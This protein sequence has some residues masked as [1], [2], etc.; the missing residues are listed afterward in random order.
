M[1][2]KK[3]IKCFDFTEKTRN[4]IELGTNVRLVANQNYIKLQENSS[5]YYPTDSDLYVKTW[6]TNPQSVK[7]WLLFESE[8]THQFDD[9]NDQITGD[10]YRLGDGTDEYWWN[11]ASWEV[12]TSDWNTEQE[13]SDNISTF[14]VTS[15]KIQVI[16]NLSTTDSEYTPVLTGIKILYSSDIEFEEDL[17]YRS[18]LTTLKENIRPISDYPVKL[19]EDSDTIDLINDFPLKTPYD[20][21]EIDSVFDNDNDPNHHTDIF[22]SYDS[23]TKVITLDQTYSSGTVIWIKF[24]YRPRVVVSTKRTYSEIGKVPCIVIS[25]YKNVFSK[26]GQK[27]NTVINKSVYEGVKV[28]AP[29][30]LD[31]DFTIRCLTDKLRDQT[32]LSEEIKKYFGQNKKITSVG[33]DENYDTWIT[34]EIDHQDF[35]S[36]NEIE[37]T[38]LKLKVINVLFYINGDEPIYS[39]NRLIINGPPNVTIS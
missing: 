9:S 19:S 37:I 1:R 24:I 20:I 26:T 5:G 32:R 14:P 17:V 18:L 22:D 29:S 30:I 23:G 38:L 12:N 31:F 13:I 10:G 15:L 36:D 28:F 25:D 21:I 33:T 35:S 6:I 27:D 16:I 34:S 7:Q 11:G 4:L 2:L 8:I 3:L 39:V